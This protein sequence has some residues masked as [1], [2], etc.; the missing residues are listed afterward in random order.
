ML[1][2]EKKE[3]LGPTQ[4]RNLAKESPYD[5]KGGIRLQDHG[6]TT[7]FRNIWIRPLKGYDEP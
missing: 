6:N 5:G 7:R 3:I 2:H 4:H 1:T